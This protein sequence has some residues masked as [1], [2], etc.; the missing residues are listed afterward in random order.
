MKHILWMA[1]LLSATACSKPE[2]DG[3]ADSGKT[4]QGIVQGRVVDGQGQGVANAEIIANSTDWHNKTTTGYTDAKGNYRFKL[5]TGVAEGSYTVSGSVTIKYHSKNFKMALY[6]ENSRVFSAYEGAVRNF[7]FRLTGKRTAD[8]DETA[9]PLGATLEV[10]HDVNHLESEN[11]ELTLEPDG[12][13]VDG[14]TGRKIVTMM[15]TAGYNIKD[16]PLGKYKISA[17]DKA[18]GQRL[19]VTIM[20][21]FKDYAPSVTGLFE[22]DD[23]IGSEHFRLGLLVGVL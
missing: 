11:I 18:S 20:D 16:I 22:D 23:F 12:P 19:G 5:P 15:P 1:V 17:R 21:S 7:V 3:P 14:S 4:E 13:L 9:S 10:H 2:I 8:D 6:E